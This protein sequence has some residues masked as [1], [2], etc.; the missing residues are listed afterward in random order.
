MQCLL[1]SEDETRIVVNFSDGQESVTV[2]AVDI[3]NI[4]LEV[5]KKPIPE[6]SSFEAQFAQQFYA[7]Y[8]RRIGPTAANFLC[9][10]KYKVFEKVKKNLFVPDEPS[11]TSEQ[12]PVSQTAT[13]D[14]SSQ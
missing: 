2:D 12:E 13:S 14:S 1:P 4:V 3:D 6:D 11:D 10:V 8:N 7:R 5:R 9:Q